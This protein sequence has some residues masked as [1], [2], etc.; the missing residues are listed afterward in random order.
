SLEGEL[1]GRLPGLAAAER[2]HA[3]G[4]HDDASGGGAG[5]QRQ[6]GVATHLPGPTLAR[7]RAIRGSRCPELLLCQ[8]FRGTNGILSGKRGQGS[9]PEL[10]ARTPASQLLIPCPFAVPDGGPCHNSPG[11]PQDSCDWP[12]SLMQVVR[13][14]LSSIFPFLN[15]SERRQ[16]VRL[17]VKQGT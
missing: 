5:P 15:L 10:L 3:R 7:L 14:D 4:Q 13:L 11:H 8:S 17:R 9:V 16:V 12:R 1:P 6:R 2:E